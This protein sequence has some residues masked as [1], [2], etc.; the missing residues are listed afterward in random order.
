MCFLLKFTSSLPIQYGWYKIVGPLFQSFY[1]LYFH[2]GCH[3]KYLHYW[4]SYTEIQ[5]ILLSH[6]PAWAKFS[7][8]FVSHQIY[9]FVCIFIVPSKTVFP[10]FLPPQISSQWHQP[11]ASCIS[12]TTD[13]WQ[14]PISVFDHICVFFCNPHKH[15]A[16]LVCLNH[17]TDFLCHIW[18]ASVSTVVQ[19]GFRILWESLF[20]LLIS[21][22]FFPA[23]FSAWKYT[24]MFHNLFV[25]D[26]A[27]M[28]CLFQQ[29]PI[30]FEMWKETNKD[31]LS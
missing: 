18:T 1:A 15:S 6:I 25:G 22:A 13:T 11:D 17:Y 12:V 28:H 7:P 16:S 9:H 5:I 8:A 2:Y 10:L 20:S 30:P 4:G 14:F 19:N 21:L 26:R 24:L 31:I 23:P 29:I 27:E 3:Q